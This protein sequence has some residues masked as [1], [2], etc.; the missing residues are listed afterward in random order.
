MLKEIQKS[1]L[2][3]VRVA[4]QGRTKM[5]VGSKALVGN[6][7]ADQMGPTIKGVSWR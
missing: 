5:I 6:T 1:D 2:K 4:G 7:V 3:I